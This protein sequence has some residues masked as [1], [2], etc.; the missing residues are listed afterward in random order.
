[1]PHINAA[2][3]GVKANEPQLF[4]YNLTYMRHFP[5]NA[6]LFAAE[7]TLHM[8]RIFIYSCRGWFRRQS[9]QLQ[10]VCDA[11]DRAPL[12]LFDERILEPEVGPR[13]RKIRLAAVFTNVIDAPLPP[14]LAP[15][16]Q[17]KL[18]APPRMKRMRD[19]KILC[20]LVCIGC[21][22]QPTPKARSKDFSE[23]CVTSSWP[24]I[25]TWV[26]WTRSI[27]SSP[28]GSRNITTPRF[29]PSSA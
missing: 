11:R 29:I 19:S 3:P 1:M 21:S 26:H 7:L 22:S 14:P 23:R 8:R 4:Q 28:S 2:P 13:R 25:W 5:R 10:Q 15:V 9:G 24:A 27:A 16:N 18:L 17:F 6:G 20:W 12:R